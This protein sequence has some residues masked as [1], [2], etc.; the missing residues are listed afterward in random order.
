M[1]DH[2]QLGDFRQ[3][4]RRAAAQ[5]RRQIEVITHRLARHL[6]VSTATG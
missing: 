5:G 2:L 4:R 6:G 3:Q 1:P